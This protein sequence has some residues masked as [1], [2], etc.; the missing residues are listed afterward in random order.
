VFAV[1][2]SWR[3]YLG[4]PGDA[5]WHWMSTMSGQYW[6]ENGEECLEVINALYA[7]T[8]LPGQN[9]SAGLYPE[10]LTFKRYHDQAWIPP[11][12]QEHASTTSGALSGSWYGENTRLL[13]VDIGNGTLTGLCEKA[14]HAL[15][16]TGF[17]DS[18]LTSPSPR[19]DRIR[20]IALVLSSEDTA[21]H[22]QHSVEALI[23]SVEC[24]DGKM[25]L[26]TFSTTPLVRY[27]ANRLGKVTLQ[28]T[29][30]PAHKTVAVP[31]KMGLAKDNGATPWYG[32]LA[33]GGGDKPEDGQLL[34]FIMDTGT[35]STWVSSKECDT[36]PCRHHRRYDPALSDS[37]V[38]VDTTE[39]TSELGPW[40]EFRFKTGKDRWQ[41]WGQSA[42]PATN[43]HLYSVDDMV[44]LEATELIDG[45]QPDGSFNRNWDD[46]VQDGSL[47]IPSDS[48]GSPSTQLLDLLIKN[49][50][51]G[52]KIV[53][54]W[55]SRAF[56]RGEVIFGGTDTNRYVTDTLAF[57]P[58]D[59]T[60]AK[61]DGESALWT[62]ALKELRVGTNTLQFPSTGMAFVLDTGSSR[63]KG[64]PG[65]INEIIRQITDNGKRPITAS[66][67]ADLSAYPDLT[68]V[69]T[70]ANGKANEY[71]LTADQYFQH[72][73]D[74]RQLAFHPLPPMAGSSAKGIFLAGSIFLDHYYTIYDYTTNPMRVGI[75]ERNGQ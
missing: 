24:D 60:I 5:S 1:A 61:Q 45:K 56:N 6:V 37:H 63:F 48:A 73:P 21:E 64:D 2:V 52:S 16:V 17:Y 25:E 54:Y 10:S 3:S 26:Y 41:F 66:P 72:F 38:F 36:I 4:G 67:E 9:K 43:R 58:V 35:D 44:F 18:D 19:D 57:Y 70:D 15:P 7:P 30:A 28:R 29:G 23:G 33:I 59:K 12:K 32:E 71:K 68:I 55:T 62:V 53:S 42:S 75:A 13:L 50:D 39:H 40:G 14:G 31:L 20:A 46:L 34:K 51:V 69:L 27:T 22:N 8:I 47:A 74:H 49:G 65:V 11:K